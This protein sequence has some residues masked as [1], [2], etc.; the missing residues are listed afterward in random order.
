MFSV[1]FFTLDNNKSAWED[2]WKLLKL[3]PA[4]LHR[5]NKAKAMR[6]LF[7]P[8]ESK[9]KRRMKTHAK[10]SPNYNIIKDLKMNEEIEHNKKLVEYLH[11]KLFPQCQ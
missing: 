3:I 11:E 1:F 7:R 2:L 10:F 5:N 6:I 9:N 4:H 8:I